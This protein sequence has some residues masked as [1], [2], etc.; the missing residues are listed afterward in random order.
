MRIYFTLKRCEKV[1][2]Y[3]YMYMYMYKHVQHTYTCTCTLYMHMHTCWL[4]L[5]N[6][7]FYRFIFQS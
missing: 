3:I 1:I 6:Q 7:S 2:A 4:L 5:S